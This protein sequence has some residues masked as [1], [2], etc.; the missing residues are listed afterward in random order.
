LR[1]INGAAE[2]RYILE[3][4]IATT[5]FI[6]AIAMVLLLMLMQTDSP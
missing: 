6:Y 4:N 2:M 3:E 5:S 1:K